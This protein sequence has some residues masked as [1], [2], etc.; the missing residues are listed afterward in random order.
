MSGN[1][2]K[3]SLQLGGYA[4]TLNYL[5]CCLLFIFIG[6]KTYPQTGKSQWLTSL[7]KEISLSAKYDNEKLSR[8]DSLRRLLLP[9]K[10][11]EL[12][13]RY[14]RLYE[15]NASFNFDSAY[16][17]TRKMQATAMQ[18]SDA[19]LINYAEIKLSFILLSS[20]M[21]KEVFDTLKNIIPQDLDSSTLAEYYILKARGFFDLADYSQ[22][23]VYTGYY[24][25]EALKYLDSSLLLF[26]ERSFQHHYFNGLKDTRAGNVRLASTHFS[27]LIN[28]PGLSLHQQAIIN[29]TFSDIYIR[30]GNIDSAIILLSKAAIAD[31]QSS[32]KETSAIFN[33]ATLLFKQGDLENASSFIQKAASDAKTYGARQRMVQLSNML[34]LI[35]AEKLLVVEKQ[36]KSISR[37]A[38]IV[39]FSFL[40]LIGLSLVIIR[41]VRKLKSQQK[42]INQKNVS[43]H[44]L[45]EEKEWLLKEI[46]HRVKNNLHTITSLLESQAAF[47]QNDALTAIRDSQHRVYAMS[48]IHQKL[49]QPE[50]NVTDIDIPVYIHELVNYLKESFETGRRIKFLMFLEPIA[51]DISLAVPLGLILNEAITNSVK[52]AFPNQREGVIKIAIKKIAE[53]TL[54]FSVADNGIGLPE[55]LE[56]DKTRSLGLKLMKGLSEDIVAKFC[57]ENKQG[58]RIAIEFDIKKSLQHLQNIS[59][60]GN[61]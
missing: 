2:E 15:E 53:D 6:F 29:S 32:T 13:A 23:K 20:G 19:A 59:G 34:P 33:L 12:F 44:H 10:N 60:S 50:K 55:G 39:T 25:N 58:T 24:N 61:K 3:I 14:L 18:N 11:Q 27:K 48:L 40:F 28:M 26:P 5:L 16:F 46:H 47:L 57:M 9:V 37:Y 22:G 35:E 56:I 41:Q 8:I 30:R 1:N 31:I 4:T 54:Q 43:L 7:K 49:Y 21:F 42:E 45:V 36:K 52:Y 17:Y 38:M 51:L